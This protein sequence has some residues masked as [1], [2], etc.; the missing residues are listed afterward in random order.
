VLPLLGVVVR[1]PEM[2]NDYIIC[3]HLEVSNLGWFGQVIKRRDGSRGIGSQ[4]FVESI[5]KV[6]H[7]SES[8]VHK[9]LIKVNFPVDRR[10]FLEMGINDDHLDVLKQLL[11]HFRVPDHVV[12]HVADC[13]FGSLCRGNEEVDHLVNDQQFIFG[14]REVVIPQQMVEEV[15]FADH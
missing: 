15:I 2:D 6:V 9:S 4:S 14:L 11:V 10:V 7:V 5:R 13:T 8:F 3:L 12:H 1:T